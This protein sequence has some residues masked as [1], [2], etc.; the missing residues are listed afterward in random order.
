MACGCNNIIH[1]YAVRFVVNV[2]RPSRSKCFYRRSDATGNR[3][4]YIIG[5]LLMGIIGFALAISTMNTAI[6]YLSL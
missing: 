2:F 4:W 6:R 5:P 1:H 3:F